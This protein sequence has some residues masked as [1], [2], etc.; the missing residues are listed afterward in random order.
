MSKKILIVEDEP[1][2]LKM[3]KLEMMHEHYEI[4]CAFDGKE[5]YEKYVSEKPDLLILDIMIPKINGLEVCR[6]IRRQ[7]KDSKT[8]VLMLTAKSE[9][10][11]RIVGRVIGAE[12]YLTKPFDRKILMQEVKKLLGDI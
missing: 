6:K 5:A 9:D 8:A 7:H 2:L 12:T 11:D 3:L 10:V 1:D 4:V